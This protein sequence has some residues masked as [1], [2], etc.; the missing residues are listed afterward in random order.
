MPYC[1]FCG[2]F[3]FA[4]P[5][6][7]VRRRALTKKRRPDKSEEDLL[8]QV[9]DFF[10]QALLGSQ[11]L[12]ETQYNLCVFVSLRGDCIAG[13]QEDPPPSLQI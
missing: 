4:G 6:A 9:V 10:G 2:F 7:R 3:L 13:E 12:R 11:E 5:V 1:G 8:G